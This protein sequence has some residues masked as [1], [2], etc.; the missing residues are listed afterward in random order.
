MFPNQRQEI[1]TFLDLNL[2]FCKIA[3]LSRF[4]RALIAKLKNSPVL[5]QHELIIKVP[6]HIEPKLFDLCY[7]SNFAENLV[8]K[9][10]ESKQPSRDLEL[11]HD[12]LAC[13]GVYCDQLDGKLT[14]EWDGLTF[15]VKTTDLFKQIRLVK[16]GRGKDKEHVRLG[17]LIIRK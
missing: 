17:K 11:M 9:L 5:R 16:W 4:E 1:Y 15:D 10:T 2:L 3:K 12:F 14:I 6:A 13:L 8:L 7:L